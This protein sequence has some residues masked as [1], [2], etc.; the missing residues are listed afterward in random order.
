MPDASRGEWTV[1][2]HLAGKPPQVV[3]LFQRFIDIAEGC[4]PFTEFAGWV[5]EAY[6]VGAG[7][8][9]TSRS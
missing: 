8:H 3:A 4:G 5:A 9:L 2:R 7:A 1:E 6:A